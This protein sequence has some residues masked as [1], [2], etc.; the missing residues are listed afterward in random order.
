[1]CL[2]NHGN[3][4]LLPRSTTVNTAADIAYFGLARAVFVILC[5][6][7]NYPPRPQKKPVIIMVPHSFCGSG[8]QTGY[9]EDTCVCSMVPGVSSGR[10]QID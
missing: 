8:M 3:L 10:P 9:G 6:I 5:C 7:K 4:V 2:V 1:M